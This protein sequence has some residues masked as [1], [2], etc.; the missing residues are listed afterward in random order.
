MRLQRQLPQVIFW[1]EKTSVCS[2]YSNQKSSTPK[3]V[4][5][6]L[7]LM[8]VLFFH[9]S[10]LKILRIYG[11]V[12]FQP[13]TWKPNCQLYVG[14][15]SWMT[16]NSHDAIWCQVKAKDSN[17]SPPKGHCDRGVGQAHTS[18]SW[19]CFFSLPEKSQVYVIIVHYK[20]HSY[21]LNFWPYIYTSVPMLRSPKIHYVL[22]TKKT[23]DNMH[24]T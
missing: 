24:I 11:C 18:L 19:I 14:F 6:L 23:H 1:C 15:P 9:I 16:I 21:D 20:S 3:L 10:I 13:A 12:S 8:D 7:L 2:R 5:T 17:L 22:E 4:F